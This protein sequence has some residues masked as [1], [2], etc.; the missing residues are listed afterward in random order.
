MHGGVSNNTYEHM[1][2]LPSAPPAPAYC[3][4]PVNGYTGDD[5]VYDV[6]P[7]DAPEPPRR[8]SGL[9]ALIATGRFDPSAGGKDAQP[10]GDDVAQHGGDDAAH[11][12]LD[13]VSEMKR[14][15]DVAPPDGAE[16]TNQNVYSESPKSQLAP[17]TDD[18]TE[19]RQQFQQ[20]Q[21]SSEEH[22]YLDMVNDE[23][24]TSD[25]VQEILRDN[26]VYQATEPAVAEVV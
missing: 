1:G 16:N 17:S 4:L 13:I 26:S 20:K 10:R 2:A 7:G 3:V 18:V 19:K 9:A 6:I 8:R 5:S 12:Y 21:A 11:E 22:T 25:P 15:S 23:K 14:D 24:Q